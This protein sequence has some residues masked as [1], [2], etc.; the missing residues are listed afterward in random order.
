[1]EPDGK[2]GV[3]A[4]AALKDSVGDA[5]RMARQ[6]GFEALRVTSVDWPQSFADGPEFY[7]REIRL[8]SPLRSRVVLGLA[9]LTLLLAGTAAVRAMNARAA[10][11]DEARIEAA[12][13]ASPSINLMQVELDLAE[14]AH[15][16]SSAVEGRSGTVPA[17]Y[18]LSELAA[19]MPP[20]IA[21]SNAE[22]GPGVLKLRGT[23]ASVDALAR[24]LERSPLFS[25]SRIE[26]TRARDKAVAFDIT[27]SV[28]A[29]GPR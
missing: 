12:R 14:F 6:W 8:R 20:D 19:S 4:A 15:A 26:G 3:M 13:K 11:A 2:P 18:V 27:V 9:A 7:S 1:M 29:R 17:W 5:V 25:G 28:N 24:A 16:S 22:Y 10:L 23:G 21:L